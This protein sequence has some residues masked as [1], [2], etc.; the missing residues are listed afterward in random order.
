MEPASF[1]RDLPESQRWFILKKD[2]GKSGKW[3]LKNKRMCFWLDVTES[4]SN[5]TIQE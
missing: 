4:K 5:S 1:F 2:T 3:L